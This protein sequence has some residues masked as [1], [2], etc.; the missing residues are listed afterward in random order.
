MK[1]ALF[2]DFNGTLSDDEPLLARIY[3]ELIDGL[4]VDAYFERYLGWT[5]EAIFRDAVGTDDVDAAIAERVDRYC[6][7]TAGG[8]TILP[9]ARD[10][11]VWATERVPVV[12][13]T[14]AFR[15]EVE[16]GLAAAALDLKLVTI[17]DV[18]APKPDPEPYARACALVGVAP[19]AAVA[20]ED[21]AT[22]VQSARAAGVACARL[23]VDIPALT[24]DA[25][26]ALLE[27]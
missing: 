20:I 18:G 17:E 21:S 10:A 4:T 6:A 7:L 19:G 12:V 24:R 11:I 16:P 8:E 22:G 26:A 27:R 2:V 13:V 23:G 9:A 5:D 25:V 1:D 14:S 15:R 3:A